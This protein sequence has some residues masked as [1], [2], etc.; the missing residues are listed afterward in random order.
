MTTTPFDLSKAVWIWPESPCWDLHNGYALFRKTFE[1]STLPNEYALLSITADQSYQLYINGNYICRGPARGFQSHWPYDQFDVLPYLKQGSNLVA[2]RAYNPGHSNFQYLTQGYAGLVVSGF[3]TDGNKADWILKTDKTWKCKKQDGLNRDTVPSSIQ[4]FCQEHIDLRIEDPGWMMPDYNDSGKEWDTHLEPRPHGGLPWHTV[5]ERGIPMLEETFLSPA[6]AVILGTSEGTSGSGYERTRDVTLLRFNEGLAHVKA[7]AAQFPTSGW[8]IPA[9]GKE[10]FRSYVV[11]FGKTVVGCIGFDIEGA[12]G[13]E[14][15]D[16]LHAETIEEDTLT[17]DFLPARHCRMAFG[18]RLIAKAGKQSHTFYHAYGFRFMLVTLRNS[19]SPLKLALH[20]RTAFYPLEKKGSFQS[21]DSLLNDIWKTSAW[22]QRVCSLDAYV[23]TPWR[24]Q[25][26]WWGDARVQ[27]KNT[28]F[29]SGDTRLIERGIAQLA[30]QATPNG[31]TYGHSPT[32]AHNCVLP[33]FTLIWM[34]T[35]WDHYWQTGSTDLLTQYTKRVAPALAYFREF[36]ENKYNLLPYDY[37][38]WLFLDWTNIFKEGYS[39]VYNLWYLI[40]L[41]KLIQIKEAAASTGEDVQTQLNQ[42][43]KDVMALPCAA[44]A[45]TAILEIQSMKD[46]AA[47]IRAAITK[48]MLLDNGL[49]C[50]G[51]DWDGKQVDHTSVHAQ[52]LAILAGL[53]PQH[54]AARI[55]KILLP[56][57]REEIKPEITPSAYWITYVFQVL[58]EAGYGAEVIPFIK[59]HWQPMVEHGTTWEGFEKG[60]GDASCS[61]AWSAHPL[62]H[63]AQILGGIY[64]AAAGW[65]S[66]TYRPTFIGENV[67]VTVPTPHGSIRSTWKREGS[68]VTAML[69]LPA[70]VSASAVLPDGRRENVT[71]E[72]TWQITV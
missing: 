48:Q 40:T 25:A 14:I 29:Y 9:T 70:G 42:A 53:E 26:Q 18:N 39:T 52:T 55:E 27:A 41:D 23:D 21:S 36:S 6:E 31:L 4:L 30:G 58:E 72:K 51:L 37:R 10:G 60:K 67:D 44:N 20:F 2:I 56:F 13:G 34:I 8:E 47:G 59:K 5:E 24:E 43:T 3:I 45:D 17:V 12:E 35:M 66:I 69:S 61:H 71:G 64:Q 38:Y 65:K 63:F 54:N 1:F 46:L 62:Y 32:M 15:V 68:A 22:T 50:D 33:D 49:L 19:T 57:I 11:D 28:F 7:D 16:T